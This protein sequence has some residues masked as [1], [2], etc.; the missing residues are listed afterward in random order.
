M[1]NA[2]T[3]PASR[4]RRGEPVTPMSAAILEAMLE[5]ARKFLNLILKLLGLPL[6]AARKT[7]RALGLG[8]AAAAGTMLQRS[9]RGVSRSST[10]PRP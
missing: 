1:T 7:A 4:R 9:R 5:L 2:S 8:G 6:V 3:H 10:R